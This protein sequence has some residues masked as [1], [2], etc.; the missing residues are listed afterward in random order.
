MDSQALIAA[1]NLLG[2]KFINIKKGKATDHQGGPEINSADTAELDDLFQQGYNTLAALNI[3][4]KKLDGIID[5]HRGRQRHHR[6]ATL[7]RRRSTKSS[8]GMV[9]EG[10]KLVTG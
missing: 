7:R 2:T 6:Q 3:M 8:V 5:Q 9:D 4:L 10:Q 1:E